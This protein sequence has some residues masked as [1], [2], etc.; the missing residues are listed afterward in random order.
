MSNEANYKLEVAA[1]V[2]PVTDVTRSLA[3]YTEKLKFESSFEWADS[4]D[5]PINYAILQNGNTEL[6]LTK[7]E[8]PRDTVAYYFV[9]GI[10]EYYETV[11]QTGVDL[12]SDIADQPWEMREFEV[13]DP[14]GNRVIF[15]EH[16]SR[17]EGA[18]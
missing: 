5:E 18:G 15:G 7:A 8:T 1:P 13:A 12:A 10:Q 11:K 16:I 17:I 2:F 9:D 3:F 6:H 4:E 14:D